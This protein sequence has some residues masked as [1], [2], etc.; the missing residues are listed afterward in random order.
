[1]LKWLSKQAEA[2]RII[3][4]EDKDLTEEERNPVWL[5]DKGKWVQNWPVIGVKSTLQINKNVYY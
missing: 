1:M 3:E 5:R 4:L 2:K